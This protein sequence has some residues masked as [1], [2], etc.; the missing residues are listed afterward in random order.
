MARSQ[1]LRLIGQ[2]RV[3]ALIGAGDGATALAATAEAERHGVPFL[4]PSALEPKI[5]AR[6]FKWVF[7]TAPLASDLARVYM[8]F[9]AAQ[10]AGGTKI[11]TLALVFQNTV[12]GASAE[13]AL[14]DA[15][16]AAGFNVV[17]ELSYTPDGID[18]SAQVKALR[19]KNPD[20]AILLSD[21]GDA[22]LFI[23]TMKT[24][25]YKPPILIG[26]DEGFSDPVFV[27]ADGNLAQ[28]LIDRSVWHV[29]DADGPSAIV[30]GLYKAKTGHDLDDASARVLQGF[31]VLADAINRAGSADPA[32]IQQALGD[33][34]LKPDQL[35]VGYNGVKFDASGQNTLAATYLTQLQGKQYVTVWPAER[36]AGT[37]A[38]PYKAWQR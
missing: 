30:N 36:A 38:L 1:V 29:G 4:V 3:A 26:N 8:E 24:F 13:A 2:G 7:R 9:L 23:R 35:I 14:R 28:G 16:Q 27:N 12:P 21:A 37:L 11:D 34:N 22:S 17:A 25:E 33:T 18:L 15:A 19:D 6:G 10:K 31:L 5:T 32:A 20:V